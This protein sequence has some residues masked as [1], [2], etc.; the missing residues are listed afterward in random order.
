MYVADLDESECD[1]CVRNGINNTKDIVGILV[2][3]IQLD[4]CPKH[5][6][7]LMRLLTVH[8]LGGTDE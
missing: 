2:D 4:L 7:E 5:I 3:N 1:Q 6:D 8:R